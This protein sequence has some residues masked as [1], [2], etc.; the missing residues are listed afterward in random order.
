MPNDSHAKTASAP[1]YILAGVLLV[2]VGIV[3]FL[4]LQP[5]KAQISTDCDTNPNS[6]TKTIR[7]G[8]VSIEAEVVTKGEDKARGLSGRNCLNPDSG[9]LFTYELTGDYCFWMKDMNF[10]I[11]MI[12][13]DDEKQIV[14]I[15]D[16]VSPD[17]YPNSF[18]P[19][20][21]AQYILEVP[22]GYAADAGWSVGTAFRWQ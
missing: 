7:A 10:A 19:D 11:D 21:P 8:S 16:S 5:D 14:T 18:C 22:A 15:K 17:T 20:K 12:W 4:V 3:S 6:E 2:V 1:K 13:M 9:M